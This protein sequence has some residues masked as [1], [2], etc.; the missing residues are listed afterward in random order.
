VSDEAILVCVRA[1]AGV[2]RVPG[3]TEARC[4]QC[5]AAVWVAPSSRQAAPTAVPRCIPC[6]VATAGD[7]VR[8]QPLTDAQVREILPNLGMQ[9]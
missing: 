1:A 8:I 5:G 3:S 6:A 9:N 2:F 7:D 4:D